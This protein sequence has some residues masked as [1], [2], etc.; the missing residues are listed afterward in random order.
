MS[1]IVLLGK[2]IITL[3]GFVCVGGVN[4][5]SSRFGL[6]SYISGDKDILFPFSSMIFLFYSLLIYLP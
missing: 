5:L 3:L 4:V 1:I 6:A 2:S